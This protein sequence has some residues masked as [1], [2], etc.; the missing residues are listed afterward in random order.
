MNLHV[1]YK[2]YEK[3]RNRIMFICSIYIYILTSNCFEF[4]QKNIFPGRSILSHQVIKH[5]G[6]TW[7]VSL[8]SCFLQMP[9]HTLYWLNPGRCRQFPSL[10]PW[11][12]T[13]TLSSPMPCSSYF[14]Q[15]SG[16][17]RELDIII[18]ML[19]MR[20]D[21]PREVSGLCRDWEGSEPEAKSARPQF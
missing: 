2:I 6:L 8:L 15:P 19:R 1:E 11:F 20:K 12:N 21:R 14:S 10:C 18:C 7:W 17:T 13:Y 16:E 9:P 3:I 4:N 5:R